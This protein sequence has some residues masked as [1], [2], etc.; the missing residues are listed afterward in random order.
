MH[1]SAMQ[2][3]KI[4]DFSVIVFPAAIPFP[5]NPKKLISFA[6]T[7]RK[8]VIFILSLSA[9]LSFCSDFCHFFN[10]KQSY[11]KE[12]CRNYIQRSVIRDRNYIFPFCPSASAFPKRYRKAIAGIRK[13][14]TFVSCLDSPKSPNCFVIRNALVTFDFSSL[15]SSTIASEAGI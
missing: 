5:Q 4:A 1:F 11:A 12:K 15:Q 6:I 13:I 3:T 14:G 7:N 2:Q 10:I 9:K 8:I